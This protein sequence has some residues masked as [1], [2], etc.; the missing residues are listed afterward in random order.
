MYA[1]VTQGGMHPKG[2]FIQ[3][4]RSFKIYGLNNGYFLGKMCSDRVIW[5]KM[6]GGGKIDPTKDTPFIK[7]PNW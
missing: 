7:V 5:V 4:N 1:K 6:F 3:P 2:I